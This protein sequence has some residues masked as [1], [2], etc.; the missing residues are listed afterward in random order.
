MALSDTCLW[1]A[2]TDIKPWLPIHATDAAHDTVL[3]ALANAVTEQIERETGRIYL[4][5]TITS[6]TQ[7]GDGTPLLLLRRYPVTS[8]TTLTENGEAVA[9]TA[10]WLESNAGIL[11]KYDGLTWST[12]DVGN[13]VCTYVAG[14]ARASIPAS[15]LSLGIDL[16]RARY[17]T[18]SSNTDVYQSIQ[19]GATNL[20]PLVDWVN[21]RKQID[22]LRYEYRVAG[23]V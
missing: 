13:I 2:L 22:A 21:I 4:T 5:R 6:E 7:S 23:V 17:L 15:V 8:I 1:A 3:E 14:Y 19:L 10:Y 11:T 12:E 18:W 9:S 16:L 20:S